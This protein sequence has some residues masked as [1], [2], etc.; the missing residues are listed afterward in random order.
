MIFLHHRKMR[1]R[2]SSNPKANLIGSDVKCLY[3]LLIFFVSKNVVQLSLCDPK[4]WNILTVS[5]QVSCSS[6]D[7][8]A[9]SFMCAKC[10]RSG[11]YLGF[12]A[13]ATYWYIISCQT[14]QLIPLK[15]SEAKAPAPVIYGTNVG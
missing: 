6:T 14:K 15:R 3:L 9:A 12:S 10:S 1:T 8:V 13:L 4:N 5:Q 11:K 2:K 7:L